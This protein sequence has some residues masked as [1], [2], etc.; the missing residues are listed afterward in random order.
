MAA[1]VLLL[2]V[3]AVAIATT[4]TSD[5]IAVVA[6]LQQENAGSNATAPI[7]NPLTTCSARGQCMGSATTP[8]CVCNDN[9]VTVDWRDNECN[10]KQHE[11][12]GPFLGNFFGGL[13]GVGFWIIGDTT[14][15]I[16]VV[17][18]VWGALLLVC[19]SAC[20]FVC[21]KIHADSGS[22]D[23]Y[24]EQ[25]ASGCH[26]SGMIMTVLW[27]FLAIG[28]WTYSW[29]SILMGARDGNGVKLAPF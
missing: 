15:G 28:M 27:G 22:K 10:Y 14:N 21:H 16:M 19:T 26:L 29:I 3:T 9:Y 13:F 6:T 11:R 1:F 20:C 23:K 12:V 2:I 18:S 8:L 4:S 25:C 17:A 24:D 7:C 5:P